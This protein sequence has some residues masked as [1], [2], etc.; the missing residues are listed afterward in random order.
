MVFSCKF[1]GWNVIHL[2]RPTIDS[3]SVQDKTENNS[4][5]PLVFFLSF[6][7]Q[8]EFQLSLFEYWLILMLIQSSLAFTD[9][10]CL[11]LL[12]RAQRRTAF[13]CNQAAW[14]CPELIFCV[15]NNFIFF[16]LMYCS[17][18]NFIMHQRATLRYRKLILVPVL[19]LS[20][21]H[22]I[23]LWP[24]LHP[25]GNPY[26]LIQMHWIIHNTSGLVTLKACWHLK[27]IFFDRFVCFYVY[28]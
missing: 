20:S 17:V 10:Y 24:K 9:Q 12:A 21:P 5:C 16:W 26:S 28:S 18:C 27:M 25:C 11:R 2:W 14:W 6:C 13:N 3:F 8:Y 22:F 23:V 19:E 1:D 7:C 15:L 4:T